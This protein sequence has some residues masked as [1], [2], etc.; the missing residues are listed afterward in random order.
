MDFE[1]ALGLLWIWCEKCMTT[2]EW[3]LLIGSFLLVTLF[4]DAIRK[5]QAH[6]QVDGILTSSWTK[7][8][9]SVDA[10]Y[11]WIVTFSYQYVLFL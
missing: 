4:S 5:T 10:E 8:N 1:D 9:V 3:E 6:S 2:P 11:H 7:G